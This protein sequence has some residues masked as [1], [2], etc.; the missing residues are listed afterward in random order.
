MVFNGGVQPKAKAPKPTA[1]PGT[2]GASGFSGVRGSYQRVR[3]PPGQAAIDKYLDEETKT[4]VIG[5]YVRAIPALKE[6]TGQD[7]SSWA[8]T[9]LRSRVAARTRVLG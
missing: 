7:W 9:S 6:A 1:N 4:Y 5:F 2:A 8:L 3:D